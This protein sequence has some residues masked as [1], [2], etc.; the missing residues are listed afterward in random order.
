MANPMQPRNAAQKN[1]EHYFKRAE[2][3]LETSGIQT[4]KRTRA[5]TVTIACELRELRLAKAIAE[6]AAD[7]LAA[8]NVGAEPGVER[9]RTP[10][11]RSILRMN[12]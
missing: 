10:A 3:Q 5:G 7:K 11:V 6:D 4:R 12:Y 2:Q 8:E 9:K 1:A